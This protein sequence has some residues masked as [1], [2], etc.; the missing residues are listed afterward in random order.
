MKGTFKTTIL[1]CLTIC[2]LLLTVAC[3][4]ENE[5]VETT[6]AQ[7]TTAQETTAPEETSPE[8]LTEE[9]LYPEP[10]KQ[11]LAE[12]KPYSLE[13]VSNGDGTCYVSKLYLN[14]R[15]EAAFDI[16]IPD[17]SP[18]GDVVTGIDLGTLLTS[19]LNMFPQYMTIERLR[20]IQ[21]QVEA[22]YSQIDPTVGKWWVNA[23][24]E[25]DIS[26][27]NPEDEEKFIEE[28][29]LMQYMSFAKFFPK[30]TNEGDAMR[31]I[32]MIGLTPR[33]AMQYYLEFAR[34]AVTAGV[35]AEMLLRTVPAYI[36]YSDCV[37]YLHIPASVNSI[38][39]E[40]FGYLMVNF[41]V[42]SI[43]STKGIVLPALDL[44]TTSAIVDDILYSCDFIVFSLGTSLEG[45]EELS[46]FAIYSPE[47][48]QDDILA[49]RY[50]DGVPT[51][52]E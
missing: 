39:A 52:W 36:N 3:K 17:K 22:D 1:L 50:V 23:Y 20:Q 51:L 41:C 8:E 40:S 21:A 38:N 10:I 27:C 48:P 12:N 24:L 43:V 4:K 5:P 19:P 7:E 16:I 18:A 44:E 9:D 11:L 25:C 29:P 45:Y 31:R 42:D 35:P 28:Y 2:I 32:R 49:W 34:E 46:N 30:M 6:T 13:F 37:R 47:E 14:N 15:Y 33:V 26:K